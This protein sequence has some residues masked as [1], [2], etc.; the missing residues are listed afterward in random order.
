[1][2]IREYITVDKVLLLLILA[3]FFS[4]FYVNKSLLKET[5]KNELKVPVNQSLHFGNDIYHIDYNT[6]SY[7]TESGHK[8]FFKDI[9]SMTDYFEDLSAYHSIP[10]GYKDDMQYQ[11]NQGYITAKTVYNDD[12]SYIELNYKGPNW[13]YDAKIDTTYNLCIFSYVEK[14]YDPI[15]KSW[16]YEGYTID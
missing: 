12:K 2:R 7:S 16:I 11:I 14:L 5:D 4:T 1:M 8:G 10:L 15:S 9:H 13:Y 3:V 6:C